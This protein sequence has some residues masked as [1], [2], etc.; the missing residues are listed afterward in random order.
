MANDKIMMSAKNGSL[1]RL[2]TDMNE[3]IGAEVNV[4]QSA[5]FRKT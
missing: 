5:A 3:E 1:L 2:L 4:D